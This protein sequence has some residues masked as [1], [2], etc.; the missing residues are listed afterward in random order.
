M[1]VS[2][3]QFALLGVLTAW[4]VHRDFRRSVDVGQLKHAIQQIYLHNPGLRRPSRTIPFEFDS[5]TEK[6][7]P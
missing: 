4:V 3:I 7:E 6:D 2:D 1:S 5:G